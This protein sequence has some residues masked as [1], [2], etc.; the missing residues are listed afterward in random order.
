[1]S[2]TIITKPCICCQEIKPLSDFHKHSQM[3]DG[4][5]NKCKSCICAYSREWGKSKAGRESDR[6]YRHSKKGKISRRR[7]NVSYKRREARIRHGKRYYPT[8]QAE[9]KAR[10]QIMI[11]VRSGKMPRPDT[12]LCVR[13]NKKAKEYHHP[14]YACEHRLDVIAVCIKCHN[15][16]H[17]K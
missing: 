7:Y 13:C 11:A 5:I 10:A 3:K 2:E 16:F 9:T 4:H 8:H 14:S 17:N 12:L 6:K 1:M 15:F